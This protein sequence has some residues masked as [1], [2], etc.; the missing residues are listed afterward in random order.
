[1]LLSISLQMLSFFDVKEF[2]EYQ[3]SISR[4]PA[5]DFRRPNY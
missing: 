1:M 5:E 2:A 4:V 3:R